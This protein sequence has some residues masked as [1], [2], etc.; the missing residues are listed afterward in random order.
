MKVEPDN[1]KTLVARAQYWFDRGDFQKTIGDCTAALKKQEQLEGTW[2]YEPLSLR[3]D[4][5]AKLGRL[6]EAIADYKAARRLDA[7]VAEAYLQRSELRRQQ[8]DTA[9]AD[10]DLAQA[11]RIDPTIQ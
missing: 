3:G 11:R 2:S 10:A 6:D 9:G 8:G 1:V 4:A 7:G 5:W